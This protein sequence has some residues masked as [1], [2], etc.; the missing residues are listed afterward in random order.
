MKRITN[1]LLCLSVATAIVALVAT[2]AFS[3]SNPKGKPF[4]TIND[5]IVEVEGA[6]STLQDQIDLLVDRVD[7]VEGR[8]TANEDAILALEAQN[9]ALE[10]LVLQN[11]SDI[12]TVEAIIVALQLANTDLQASISANS[13]DIVILQAEVDANAAL[14]TTLQS[15]L[16]MLQDNIITLDT[17]LQ[18][19]IDNNQALI[20]YLTSEV[21]YIK[22]ALDLKQ[23]LVDGVCPDG[24]AIQQITPEGTVVCEDV[25]GISG[26][27]HT[28]TA[29]G[30]S[31]TVWPMTWVETRAYCPAGYIATGVGSFV[32]IRLKMVRN[33]TEGTVGVLYVVNG[34]GSPDLMICVTT[35]T[36][37]VP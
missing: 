27:L 34:S 35:C 30:P 16:L 24:A 19:Q 7:T 32:G 2:P 33:Y 17:S 23:D 4:I 28:V 18:G 20:D 3:G 14:I 1:F 25:G 5:Q 29:Y 12:T 13:G 22:D 11:V 31:V 36:R 6:V 8:V 9:V 15:A 26:Q 21:V 37:I 10:A